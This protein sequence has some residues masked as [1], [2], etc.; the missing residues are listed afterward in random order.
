MQPPWVNEVD[1]QAGKGDARYAQGYLDEPGG[2]LGAGRVLL[3]DGGGRGAGVD[4][5]GV[6]DGEAAALVAILAK[7]FWEVGG[8]GHGAAERS[9]RRRAGER[10]A[11]GQQLVVVQISVGGS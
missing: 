11:W 3:L 2:L 1:A 7:G 10:W 4:G 5:E 8:G 6:G 9:L